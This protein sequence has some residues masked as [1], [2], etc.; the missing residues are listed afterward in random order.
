MNM[1]DFERKEIK[2]SKDGLLQLFSTFIE[3][4]IAVGVFEGGNVHY[5]P[6]SDAIIKLG[7]KI[8]LIEKYLGVENG[9]VEKEEKK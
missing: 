6:I 9:L 4:Q 3:K 2:W 7:Q 8:E 1:K 5:R